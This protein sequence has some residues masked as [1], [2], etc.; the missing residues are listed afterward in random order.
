MIFRSSKPTVG[1]ARCGTTNCYEDARYLGR[2]KKMEVLQLMYDDYKGYIKTLR[3][4]CR[5]IIIEGG[6][7]LL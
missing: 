6:K 7:V 2:R 3:H 4:A 1:R 5:G